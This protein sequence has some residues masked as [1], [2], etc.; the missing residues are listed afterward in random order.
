MSSTPYEEGVTRAAV[1]DLGTVFAGRLRA[2]EAGD[3]AAAFTVGLMYGLGIGVPQDYASALRWYRR[4][5]EH[6]LPRAQSNLGFMYGTGRGV[7]QDWVQAYA[8]YNLAAA[9]GEDQ[10]RRNRDLVASNIPDPL[11]PLGD[12][13]V[14]RKPPR[15]YS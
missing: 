2:A 4:A 1:Q 13:P 8:W 3:G 7:P 6:G 12:R 15:T 10:A 9:G 5:A 14:R 11:L